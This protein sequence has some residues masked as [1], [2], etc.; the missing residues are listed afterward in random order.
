MLGDETWRKQ[1]V[2]CEHVK[3]GYHHMSMRSKDFRLTLDI[4]GDESELYDHRT[5]PGELH[6]RWSDPD[7]RK[8]R[9]DLLVDMLR[10]RTCP[11]LLYGPPPPDWQP[12]Q[13]P[14]YYQPEWS[15]AVVDVEKGISWSEIVARE[16]K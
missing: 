14:D 5:D 3:S 7:Y 16:G 10:F 6:N 9:E 2:L 11:P 4:T 12:D 13:E 1:A 8:I 15:Q